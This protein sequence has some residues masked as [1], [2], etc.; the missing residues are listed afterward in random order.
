M[1]RISLSYFLRVIIF[2]TVDSSVLRVQKLRSRSKYTYLLVTFHRNHSFSPTPLIIRSRIT[3]REK[4]HIQFH[5]KNIYI[6]KPFVYSILFSLCV[7][8]RCVAFLHEI[9]LYAYLCIIFVVSANAK[10]KER[11]DSAQ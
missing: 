5:N 2:Q 6:I 4:E 10:I 3:A 7:C 8:M 9:L 1:D 11:D